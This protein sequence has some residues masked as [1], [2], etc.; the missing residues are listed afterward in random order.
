MEV[1]EVE[2]KVLKR[3]ARVQFVFR[4]V[5]QRIDSPRFQSVLVSLLSD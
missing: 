1:G 3:I 5:L 4:V 2:A